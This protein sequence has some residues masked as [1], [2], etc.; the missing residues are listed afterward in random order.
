MADYNVKY[1]ISVDVAQ[2]IAA[3]NNLA[4]AAAKLPTVITELNNLKKSFKGLSSVANSITPVTTN[5]NNM[6]TQMT[7]LNTEMTKF[8][9]TASKA[10][11]SIKGAS[12]SGVRQKNSTWSKL[13]KNGFGLYNLAY[14][15][16]VPIVPGM[17]GTMLFGMAVKHSLDAYMDYE[18]LMVTTK[19][20][21]KSTDTDLNTFNT[22]FDAMS[23][24]IRQIG[25]D[26]KFTTTEVAGAA[27]FLAMAG[28]GIDDVNNSMKSIAN[29]ATIADAPLETVADVVTNIQTAYGLS[30]K[31]MPLIADI[32][33]S[34]ST[35]SN[36]TILS[37]GEAMKF[38]APMMNM[39][40]ISFNEA[41]AAIG[42]LGNAGLK[43][44][45]AGTA[46]R[47]MMTRLLKPT[48]QGS[49]VLKKYNIQLYELDKVTQRT[50][51]RSLT[52]IFSQLSKADVSIPEMIAIFDKIGGNASNNIFAKLLQLP[53]LVN[54][55]VRSVGITDRIAKEK[56]NTI[57]GKWDQVISQFTDTG[58]TA[59]EQIAPNIK[60]LLDNLKLTFQNPGVANF[61][62]QITK[63]LMIISEL[64]T[65]IIGLMG[66][67]SNF[68]STLLVGGLV[69][70]TLIPVGKLLSRILFGTGGAIRGFGASEIILRISALFRLLRAGSALTVPVFAITTALSAFAGAIATIYNNSTNAIN[71]IAAL[72][73]EIDQLRFGNTEPININVNVTRNIQDVV[74]KNT[75]ID[76]SSIFGYQQNISVFQKQAEQEGF[77]AGREIVNSLMASVKLNSSTKE[78][79]DV[80]FGIA[81]A[82]DT[83]KLTAPFAMYNQVKGIGGIKYQVK[84]IKSGQ[85]F[86]M[87]EENYKQT[88]AYVNPFNEALMKQKEA[89]LD[90]FKN[91]IGAY[92]N[93]NSTG[94]T[95]AQKT[96]AAFN[97]IQAI[98]RKDLRQM[99]HLGPYDKLTTGQILE[100]QNILN[101]V[102]GEFEKSVMPDIYK[103]TMALLPK[104]YSSQVPMNELQSNSHMNVQGNVDS[105]GLGSNSKVG[106]VSAD[107][108]KRITLNIQ[109]LI[110]SFT[111][112]Y[113]GP[114]DQV[115]IKDIV[116]QTIIDAANEATMGLMSQS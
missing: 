8:S 28:M 23:K 83:A 84:D 32:L 45:V 20:V 53:E 63:S 7:K 51:L 75:G 86:P 54:R 107:P 77:L 112:E 12:I 109:N 102:L 31:N 105:D 29:L 36:T 14:G 78:L 13:T 15:L 4:S 71:K 24:N 79:E 64:L 96:D 41:A 52:D 43:G 115:K 65:G 16:G 95:E 5:L 40:K 19:N 116:M 104:D 73:E 66:K 74:S 98:T 114:E 35:S 42:V 56:Q 55:S 11:G 68:S 3:L 101:T 103:I 18:N 30:S 111:V 113:N 2:A 21:L 25:I 88:T 46:L 85:V 81:D 72:N 100:N 47:A 91:L 60:N 69:F 22:R 6:H 62:G 33:T 39:A 110:G 57:K 10:F 97:F 27:K 48:K 49:E 61:F 70:K 1:N 89:I 17:G 99:L 76:G 82:F 93:I 58:M 67:F 87:T 94:I 34:I 59:F 50:K 106:K 108:T 37:M 80:Q 26:T 9:N 38:A 90:P 92:K 44:T